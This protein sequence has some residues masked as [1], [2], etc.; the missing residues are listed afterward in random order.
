MIRYYNFSIGRIGIGAQNGTIT[1][2]ILTPQANACSERG[3]AKDLE[4]IEAAALQIEAYLKGEI[5]T[6]DL[7]L[8]PSGTDFMKSVWMELLKIPY[9]ETR[10][11]KEIAISIGRNKA[12]RAVGMANNRNPIP[13][14]IPCHRVIGSN[15]KMVGYG[16]GIDL[17]VKLLEIENEHETNYMKSI[18]KTK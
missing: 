6:F 7:P 10:S 18:E 11:Y 17:K 16:G 3:V 9:G 2:V 15:G 12:Y 4:L 1:Q 14:I 8:N 13:I 5:K